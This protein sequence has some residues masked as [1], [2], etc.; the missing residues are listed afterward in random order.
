M[1]MKLLLDVWAQTGGVW[2]RSEKHSDRINSA[3]CNKKVNTLFRAFDFIFLVFPSAR[4][5]DMFQHSLLVSITHEW[6]N[7]LSIETN[8]NFI[9][10]LDFS[11]GFFDFM[12]LE[13]RSKDCVVDVEGLELDCDVIFVSIPN[14]NWVGVLFSRRCIQRT[15][16]CL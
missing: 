3:I 13:G 1:N 9:Q 8:I 15:V 11:N 5:A 4:S 16:K 10:K 12:A 6:K 14:G 7:V 2:K